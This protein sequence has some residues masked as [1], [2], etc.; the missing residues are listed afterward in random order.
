MLE[1]WEIGHRHAKCFQPINFKVI[2]ARKASFLENKQK[3]KN[4]TKRVLHEMAEGLQEQMDIDNSDVDD[5]TGRNIPA[6]RPLGHPTSAC[7]RLEKSVCD[8]WNTTYA[9]RTSGRMRRQFHGACVDTGA[10][11][12]VIDNRQ[13]KAYCRRHKLKF[14]LDPSITCFR[15]GDRSYPSLGSMMIRIPIPNGSFLS[16]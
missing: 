15:F 5:I 11:K 16:I 2:A 13:A 4:G 6:I 14:K 1:L 3:K 8:I 7:I 12:S 10:Q 9:G